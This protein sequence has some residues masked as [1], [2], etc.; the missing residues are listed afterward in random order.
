[1]PDGRNLY[2]SLES[3]RTLFWKQN[4]SCWKAFE[5]FIPS[6]TQVKFVEDVLTIYLFLQTST[7]CFGDIKAWQWA[8]VHMWHKLVIQEL[9]KHVKNLLKHFQHF[10]AFAIFWR[11][12][13]KPA[14][15]I[16]LSIV[17]TIPI[18]RIMQHVLLIIVVGEILRWLLRYIYDSWRNSW[19]ILMTPE[20]TPQ[21]YEWFLTWLNTIY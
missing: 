20:V 6:S 7:F 3:P 10:G 2:I 1:M 8:I 4:Q 5:T 21:I 17:A 12:P 18:H 11:K 16:H 9:T 15:M 19:D 14:R 13:S